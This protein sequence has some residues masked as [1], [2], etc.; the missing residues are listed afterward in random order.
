MSTIRHTL[1]FLAVAVVLFS[2]FFLIPGE[3]MANCIAY[4]HAVRNGHSAPAPRWYS[5][6]D[7]CRQRD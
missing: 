6:P 5:L 2:T 7:L 4:D 3:I 1:G